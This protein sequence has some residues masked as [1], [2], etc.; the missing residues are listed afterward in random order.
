M[1]ADVIAFPGERPP[2]TAPDPDHFKKEIEQ[3]AK[4]TTHIR[5]WMQE[6]G[7]ATVL[8]AVADAYRD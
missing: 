8:R 3:R 7:T 5:D 6:H 2:D 1:S 4:L